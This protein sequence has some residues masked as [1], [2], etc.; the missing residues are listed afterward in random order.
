MKK[1]TL[2][3]DF[4]VIRV[5][6]ILVAAAVVVPV[7]VLTGLPGARGRI[8]GGHAGRSPL[9]IVSRNKIKDGVPPFH[10]KRFSFCLRIV[11]V[12]VRGPDV[13]AVDRVEGCEV[14]VDDGRQ[15]N[16]VLFRAVK[17]TRPFRE[18]RGILLYRNFKRLGGCSCFFS[19]RR[20]P[21]ASFT[22]LPA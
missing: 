8:S 12:F 22:F 10:V 17:W 9:L 5:D 11:S 19:C 2:L 16:H 6:L 1:K 14:V 21:S 20:L 3:S 18:F 4:R 7:H 15:V 13:A